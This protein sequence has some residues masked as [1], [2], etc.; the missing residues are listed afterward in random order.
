LRGASTLCDELPQCIAGGVAFS[1]A[2]GADLRGAT[3]AS[4]CCGAAGITTA[5]LDGVTTHFGIA[6]DEYTEKDLEPLAS[7]VG[8][9]GRITFAPAYGYSGTQTEFSG[10]ELREL[11]ARLK[12]MAPASAHPSFDC[13]RAGTD[14]EKAVCADPKLAA[15]DAALNWLWQRI[16]HTP[17]ETDAQKKWAAARATCP[18]DNYASSPDAISFSSPT[19][20]HSCIGI[21]YAERIRALAPKSASAAAVVGSG[22]YTTDAPL[23]LPQGLSSALARKFIIARGYRDDEIDLKNWGKGG[24]K[25]TGDGLWANG[26]SCSLEAAESE[27]Q[28]TGSK[29]RIDDNPKA[30]N[31]QDSISFVITPQVIVMAGGA[32]QF[33][34]GARG[35]WSDIYFRQPID[36]ISAASPLPE[37]R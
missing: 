9:A 18:P 35:G 21:A 32:K 23:E 13:S 14:V 12:Q 4:L 36:L 15:L 16:P 8:E 33:N 10:H 20:S 3:I 27:T 30:P 29:V 6:L 26:H 11:A 17:Q 1:S 19:I 34:C 5:K 2:A 28:R 7:G 22:R 25:I 37:A 24:G 31:D